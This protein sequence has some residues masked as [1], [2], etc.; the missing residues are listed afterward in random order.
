HVTQE[1]T[2]SVTDLQS[3]VEKTVTAHEEPKLTRAQKTEIEQTELAN[4]PRYDTVQDSEQVVAE[5]QQQVKAF[6]F[7]GYM[8]SGQGLN[9]EA[10]V[11]V[12]N[13]L[14]SNPGAE[15]WAGER[16]YRRL[17]IDI[18]DF[19][20]LDTSGYGGGVENLNVKIG[21]MS[22]AYLGGAKDDLITSNGIYPKSL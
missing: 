4:T 17:N 11:Q 7:H 16:Y 14:K 13:V 18:N 21:Q 3:E 12:G 22:V 10:C 6:E 9:S 5:L 2:V 8:R 19:Y 20:I 1:N 15:F